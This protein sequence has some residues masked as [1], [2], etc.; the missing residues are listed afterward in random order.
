MKEIAVLDF[1]IDTDLTDNA[2]PC[3]GMMHVLIY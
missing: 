1:G 2:Q 3:C